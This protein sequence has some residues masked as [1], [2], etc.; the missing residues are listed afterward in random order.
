MTYVSKSLKHSDFWLDSVLESG[1]SEQ[2]G[3]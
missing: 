2:R 1:K 3:D